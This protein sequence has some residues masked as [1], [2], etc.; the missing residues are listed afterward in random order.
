MT[1]IVVEISKHC[2]AQSLS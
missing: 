1:G 2:F